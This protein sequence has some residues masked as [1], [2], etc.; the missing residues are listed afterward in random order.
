MKYKQD[1][2][3]QLANCMFLTQAENG[4]SGK[5][6]T[7]PEAWFSGKPENYLDM[8]LIPRDKDLWKIDR[9]EDFIEERKRLIKTKFSYLLSQKT[10]GQVAQTGQ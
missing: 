2:R 9:F 6:D 5:S 4:A 3:D 1:A 8:H 7:L 10:D